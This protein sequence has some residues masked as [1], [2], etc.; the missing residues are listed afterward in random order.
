MN[1][2]ILA[3][4]ASKM[5]CCHVEKIYRAAKENNW[6]HKIGKQPK[7]GGITPKLYLMSDIMWLKEKREGNKGKGGIKSSYVDALNIVKWADGLSVYPRIDEIKAR[8]T[9]TYRIPD[10]ISVIDNR[11]ARGLPELCGRNNGLV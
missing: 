2:W 7:G 5:L 3:S 4:D 6:G 9:D 11:V 8:M 10:I 1:K